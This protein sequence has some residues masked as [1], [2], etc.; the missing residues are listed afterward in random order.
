MKHQGKS[1]I[2]LIEKLCDILLGNY[3]FLKSIPKNTETPYC[4][5]TWET[6]NELTTEQR[7]KRLLSPESVNLSATAKLD[8]RQRHDSLV[9]EEDLPV[10]PSD[11]AEKESPEPDLKIWMARISSQLEL[12]ASKTD[13]VG[14]ATKQDINQMND[15]IVA[16]VAEIKQLRDEM[17]QYKKDFEALRLSVD[18]AEAMKLNKSYETSDRKREGYNVNNMTDRERLRQP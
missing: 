2:G 9:I 18:Q 13:I 17:Q 11:M 14:L 3:L 5:W 6:M 8:K 12:A 10:K 1:L 4:L 16:Q 15:T 7:S